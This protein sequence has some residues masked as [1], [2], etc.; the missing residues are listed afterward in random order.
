M[1]TIGVPAIRL[2]AREI[3]RLSP[4]E[5]EAALQNAAAVAEREYRE[6]AELTS[7]EAFGKDDLHGESASS[8]AR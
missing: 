2:T 5:R 6:N 3:R 7:F 4:A 1:A 8:E